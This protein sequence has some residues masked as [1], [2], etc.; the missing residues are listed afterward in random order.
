MPDE[1]SPADPVSPGDPQKRARIRPGDRPIM[2]P[3]PTTQWP[4]NMRAAPGKGTTRPG[5]A[6][7]SDV[8]ML[9]SL[10]SSYDIRPILWLNNAE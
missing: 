10:Q 3:K 2:G 8:N 7:T 1:P 6:K 5:R 9:H 4:M